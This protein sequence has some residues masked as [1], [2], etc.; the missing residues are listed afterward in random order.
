[1]CKALLATVARGS[2][3]IHCCFIICI[4]VWRCECSILLIYV[5]SLCLRAPSK[6]DSSIGLH[7][8]IKSLLT[9]LL[10]YGHIHFIFTLPI[11]ALEPDVVKAQRLFS[12]Q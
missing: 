10:T 7:S 6:T 8:L 3:S 9:Y 5:F 2:S 4:C 12:L 11:F 1:M